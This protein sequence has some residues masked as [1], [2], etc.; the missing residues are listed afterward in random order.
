MSEGRGPNTF[1]NELCNFRDDLANMGE[2]INEDKFINELCNFRDDL[3]NMGEIINE[4]ILGGDVLAGLFDE[5]TQRKD[6]VIRIQTLIMW[7]T[8][9]ALHVG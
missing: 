8:T 9:T 6:G 2:I 5:F 4:D 7:T 3:V 1:V